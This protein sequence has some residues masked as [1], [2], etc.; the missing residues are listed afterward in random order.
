M[1]YHFKKLVPYINN[2]WFF[3]AIVSL[4]FIGLVTFGLS[5]TSIGVYN[6]MVNGTNS[7][8]DSLIIGKIQPIRSDE[9]IVISQMTMA[10]KAE[11][12]P[13]I[14]SNI[15]QGQNMNI[16][17][18]VPTKD[19]SQ[20]FRPQNWA[21]YI[22]PL[23]NAFAY[24]W[25]L[26]A[27]VLILSSYFFVLKLL[28]KKYFLASGISL[29]L[30]YSGFVQWWY[31]GTTLASLLYPIL[32][33]L[34]YI[35]LLDK[36]NTTK[37]NIIVSIGIIYATIALAI[38]LY[39]PF[40]I[41]A[42]LVL[43]SFVIG[44]TL[45]QYGKVDLIHYIKNYWKYLS[46]II[47]SVTAVL[48]LFILSNWDVIEIVQN[49]SYPGKR[50][51]ES[52][53]Y[54][55]THLLSGT[56]AFQH[57]NSP[58]SNAYNIPSANAVNSSESSIFIFMGL[59]VLPILIL[60][61]IKTKRIFKIKYSALPISLL[62]CSLIFIAWLFLPNMNLLGEIT[63]L[64]LVPQNRLIIG[65]GLLSFFSLVVFIQLYNKTKMNKLWII[66]YSIFVLIIYLT[67]NIRV[68]VLMP[69]FL[70]LAEAIM[71]ALP[72]ALSMY[73]LLEQKYNLSIFIFCCFVIA[74]SSMV[75]PL[76]KGLGIINSNDLSSYIKNFPEDNNYW[77]AQDIFLENIAIIN[78]K[79]SLSG[80]FA[81]PQVNLWNGIDNGSQS[82][83]Y[84]RY[85]HVSYNFDQ[86]P[87]VN[88]KT[89]FV[90]T[91]LDQLVIESELCSDFVKNAGIRHIV[92][93]ANF[94]KSDQTCIKS[95]NELFFGKTKFFVYHL[96]FN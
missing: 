32:I 70:S 16:I 33:A 95:T 74:S 66:L 44:Y 91:G 47:I 29:G 67:I 48:G 42:L 62:L 54:S 72:V 52:G 51:V 39:P 8:D 22:L 7:N 26:P 75:N 6:Q 43:L 79:K 35:T 2:I 19:W 53:S 36:N 65:L 76:Y 25:W 92:S 64:K 30:F 28:S 24:R 1:I 63:L 31:I 89:W 45:Q 20:I 61:L 41:P 77:V 38:V 56:L 59:M 50:I 4:T 57:Q 12:F 68:H 90:D 73:L 87:N 49:T 40:Q 94:S 80:V 82:D 17:L 69:G 83:R 3:P 46:L 34:L 15:G 37:K 9:W 5:G 78:G 71:L 10:Q 18:D 13:E 21:F 14:N 84:N 23:E 60:Q 88:I 11:N 93:S 58:F 27:L 81:Y 85:A 86:N 55:I 96:E